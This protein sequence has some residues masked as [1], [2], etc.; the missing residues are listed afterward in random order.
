M[1]NRQDRHQGILVQWYAAAA[2]FGGLG[3]KG[4]IDAALR[5]PAVDIVIVAVEKLKLHLRIL[6]LELHHHAGQPVGGHAGKGADADAPRG[7]G[8]QLGRLLAQ[9]LLLGDDFPDERDD[10]LSLRGEPRTGAGAPE[11]GKLQLRFHG[12]NDMADAGL[13]QAQLLRS[14]GERGFF[15]CFFKNFIFFDVHL[16]YLPP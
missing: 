2:R 8:T 5:Q 11:Q 15:D 6:L 12:G 7:A 16:V 9:L 4:Q 13:G 1:S 10:R 14:T 3:G